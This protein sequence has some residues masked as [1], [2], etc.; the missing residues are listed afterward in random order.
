VATDADRSAGVSEEIEIG[1]VKET[2][3][4]QELVR[5]RRTESM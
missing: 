2:G 3:Y 4:Q 5:S 1:V